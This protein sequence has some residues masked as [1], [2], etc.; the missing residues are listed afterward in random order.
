MRC[1]RC[2]DSNFRVSW[3]SSNNAFESNFG[4]GELG[5]TNAYQSN[6][7]GSYAGYNATDLIQ[8]S[9]DNNMQQVLLIQISLVLML[10]TQ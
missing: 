6:F 10:K 9:F 3:L 5:I 8:I 1:I 7:I 4:S 2:F